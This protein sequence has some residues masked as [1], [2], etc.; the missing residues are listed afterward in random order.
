MRFHSAKRHLGIS[1]VSLQLSVG[2]LSLPPSTIELEDLVSRVTVGIDETRHD[3]DRTQALSS[4]FDCASEDRP[5]GIIGRLRASGSR[6]LTE[7]VV[8]PESPQP[9]RLQRLLAELHANNEIGTTTKHGDA[10]VEAV[11]RKS[12][13][14]NSSHHS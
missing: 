4:A 12:T 3:P 13:R 5:F 1:E 2:E 9:A 8:L 14:L 11:D 6:D 7:P 10:P